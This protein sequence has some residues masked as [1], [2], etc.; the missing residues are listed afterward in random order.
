MAKVDAVLAPPSSGAL[1][2]K[3]AREFEMNQ[4]DFRI[5]DMT[6]DANLN[7]KPD[8]YIFVYSIVNRRFEIRRPPSFP[9]ITI[10]ACPKGEPWK[11]VAVFPNIVNEKWIDEN[12]QMRVNGIQG[13]RFVMDLLNPL[14]LGVDMWKDVQ[15][16]QLTWMD[17]GGTDDMTR[18]GLFFSIDDP[19]KP[20]HLQRTKERMENHYRYLL[21][22]ADELASMNT[23]EAQRSIGPEHH[24]AA[25]YFHARS[26]WHVI[27]ELPSICENC[28]EQITDGVAYHRNSMGMICVR[29]WKK[30]VAAGVK[31]K[32]EVPDELRW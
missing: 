3:R 16:E 18:R 25:D 7:R 4:R 1:N 14:N 5:L 8:Y 12:N 27:A 26:K 30:A 6:G 9:L 31:T 23:A 24:M 29:D 11:K 32:A 13:E 22:Q 21:K 19:P 20:E 15:D 17:A 28:G 2:E 10:P